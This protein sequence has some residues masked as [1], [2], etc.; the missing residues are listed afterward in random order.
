MS[1]TCFTTY[2]IMKHQTHS[3]H[4]FLLMNVLKTK[5]NAFIQ[6]YKNFMQIRC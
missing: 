3:A 6:G 1:K 2:S 4:S 5:N